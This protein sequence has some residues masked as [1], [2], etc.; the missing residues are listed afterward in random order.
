MRLRRASVPTTELGIGKGEHQIAACTTVSGRPVAATDRAFYPGSG[1]RIAW[2]SIA[3]AEWDEPFLVI[4]LID[5]Q[6]RPADRLRVELGPSPEALAA[7]VHDRVTGSVLVTERAELP[8]GGAALFTARRDS[9]DGSIRWAV[10]FDAGI[11][12]SDPVVRAEA[13]EKLGQLRNSLG[14]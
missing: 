12:P 7:A 5:A 13:T 10:V 9:D 11:D 8:S 4:V 2:S 1:Q 6:G 3:K 14:I